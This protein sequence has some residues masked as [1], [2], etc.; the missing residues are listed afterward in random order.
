MSAKTV[1]SKPL[2]SRGLILAIVI[3]AA[4]TIIAVAALLAF[5]K[6]PVNPGDD[7]SPS[8]TVTSSPSP[9]SSGTPEPSSSPSASEPAP[10]TT[11][12]TAAPPPPAGPVFASFSAPSTVTCADE[13]DFKEVTITWSGT[14]AV[15][16]WI[17]V[18]TNNAKVEPYSDVPTSGSYTLGF[19]CGNS[20]Q[21]YTVTLEDSDGRL[22]HKTKDITRVM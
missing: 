6:P 19:P 5:S 2:W 12:T 11:E 17:G 20:H 22:T 7:P 14:G 8:D 1:S 16:A 18:D 15:N 21:T 3:I 10:A 4:V 9:T 13:Y